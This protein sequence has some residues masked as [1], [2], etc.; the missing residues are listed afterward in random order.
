MLGIAVIGLGEIGQIYTKAVA[1]SPAA[2]LS[3][4]CDVD[5]AR[6]TWAHSS[7]GVPTTSRFDD[8]LA[9]K[10]VDV[11][12]VC[13]PHDL[14][15]TVGTAAL[16]A[17][18]HVLLEKPMAT[19]VDECDQLIAAAAGGKL[20]LGVSHNRLFVPSHIRARELIESGAIGEPVLLRQRLGVHEPYTGWRADPKKSGGGLLSDSGA[21]QFYVAR[22]LFGEIVGVRSLLDVP[23]AE[24]E[25]LAVVWME[26]ES[27]A[28]GLFEAS[29]WGPTG[30]FDDSIEVVGSEGVLRLGGLEAATFGYRPETPLERYRDRKW[31]TDDVEFMDWERTVILSVRAYLEALDQGR[32]VP[33]PGEDG[34]ETVRL[35]QAAYGNA[36]LLGKFTRPSLSAAHPVPPR[37]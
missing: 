28:R 8:A 33:T 5:E 17:G 30:M 19:T 2:R 11:V 14:H 6:L 13:L 12:A 23:Y 32:P 9:R 20:V 26:F 27:G 4:A 37:I 25:S 7:F 21:H 31:T 35:I 18:K 36:T 16:A 3:I 10:D 15:V 22:H 29:Y 24:G 1:E 34:R